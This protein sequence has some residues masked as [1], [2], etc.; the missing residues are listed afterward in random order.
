MS[1]LNT[2]TDHLHSLRDTAV[3]FIH[4]AK[5]K[6]AHARSQAQALLDRS[7]VPQKW[8]LTIALALVSAL[9]IYAGFDSMARAA[10]HTLMVFVMALLAWSVLRLP[11]TP[12][13]IGAGLALMALKATTAEDFYSGMG[14][15][16]IWLLIGAFLMAA[17]LR[18]SGVAQRL[19]LQ[20]VQGAGTVRALFI[21]L[22]WIIIATA[23]VVPSTSGRAALLLPLFAVMATALRTSYGADTARSQAVVR[24]L[25]LLFPTIILLSAAASLLGAG[26]HLI[27]VDFMSRHGE[28]KTLNYLQWMILGTPFAILCSLAATHV[29]LRSFM[30]HEEQH[31]AVALPAA[32]TEPMT[33]QQLNVLY[34]VGGAVLLWATSG[35]HGLDAAVIALLAML[36]VTAKPLTGV[37]LKDGLKQVEWNLILFLAATLVMG[38]ALIASGAAQWLSTA[39]LAILPTAWLREPIWLVVI[40]A[41]ISLASHLVI[42]SRTA[43]AMVL[44]PTVALPLAAGSYEAMALIFLTVMASGF[45]QTFSVS[46]KPVALFAKLDEPT[47]AES[48]LMRLSMLLAPWMLGLLVV[49]AMHIWPMLGLSLISELPH[50]Q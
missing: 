25:A 10:Q 49:F 45:C 42:T 48:D 6:S 9:I 27:A 4:N 35:W 40:A 41:I 5:A 24:A 23:F 38:E 26:A 12:V 46:A 31:S 43:R 32:P 22:T 15:D 3:Q 29:I 20:A 50:C 39:S 21:R 37:S 7:P 14:D 16:L 34:I 11:E 8:L 36:L 19:A 2:F 30:S 18:S 47:Y 44:I 17:V 1:A 28:G 13:A 33:R